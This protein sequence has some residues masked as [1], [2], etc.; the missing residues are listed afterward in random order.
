VG[1]DQQQS[2]EDRASLSALAEIALQLQE[3]ALHRERHQGQSM[4][5]QAGEFSEE[6]PTARPLRSGAPSG[7]LL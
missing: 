4:V 1:G 7:V 6:Y 5:G 3:A 2:R